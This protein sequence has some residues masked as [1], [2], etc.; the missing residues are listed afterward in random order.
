MP[1]CLERRQQ[2]GNLHFIT[3]SCH[4]RSPYLVTPHAASIFEHS[5]ESIRH[6]YQFHLHGYVVMP[7]HVHLLLSEPPTHPL[8][9]VLGSLKRS[10]SKHLPES[11]F[12]LRA[13]TTS[14]SSPKT[15]ASK[16]SATFIAIP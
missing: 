12:W 8:S 6:K 10:V 9:T 14:T 4:G 3:F 16:N 2:T 11:P 13:I 5:L 1:P 15:S 7:E